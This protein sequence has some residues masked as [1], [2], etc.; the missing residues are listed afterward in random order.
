MSETSSSGEDWMATFTIYLLRENVATA[1][2]AIVVG[3]KPHISDLPT[4][5]AS[6]LYPT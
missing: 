3:A 4:R 5:P 2:D 1:E 6:D